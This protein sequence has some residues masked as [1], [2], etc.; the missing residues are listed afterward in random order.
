[1]PHRSYKKLCPS[2]RMSLHPKPQ[3]RQLVIGYGLH[4]RL[5][6]LAVLFRKPLTVASI[7]SWVWPA[8]N[9]HWRR[10][11]TSLWQWRQLVLG[12]GLHYR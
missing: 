4:Y 12:Y 6:P 3:W 1:M 9:Y 7:G 2:L 5:L 11:L 8:A 10:C